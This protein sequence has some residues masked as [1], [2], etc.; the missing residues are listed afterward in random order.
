MPHSALSRQDWR[1]F[2]RV[3]LPVFEVVIISKS[4]LNSSMCQGVSSACL[5]DHLSQNAPRASRAI[6]PRIPLVSNTHSSQ[7]TVPVGNYRGYGYSA[8]SSGVVPLTSGTPALTAPLWLTCGGDTRRICLDP[9]WPE[10]Y[11]QLISFPA[12]SVAEFFVHLTSSVTWA[13]LRLLP[14]R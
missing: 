5:G 11:T 8:W 12:N 13:F 10:T 14:Y 6:I 7:H 1:W 9:L 4:K 3:P 2:A